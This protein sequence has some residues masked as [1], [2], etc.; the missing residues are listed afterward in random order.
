[1][2]KLKPIGLLIIAQRVDNRVITSLEAISHEKRLDNLSN[3]QG[4][5][6]KVFNIQGT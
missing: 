1:M 4:S 2:K 5:Q 3:K 6:E